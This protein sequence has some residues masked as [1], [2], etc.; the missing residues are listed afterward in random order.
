MLSLQLIREHPDEVRS[1]LAR[2]GASDAPPGELLRPDAQRRRTL[3]EVEALR[4]ERNALPK[5]VGELARLM[6]PAETREAKHAEHRRSDLVARSSFLGDK[7]DA[8]ETQLRDLDGDLRDL[9]LQVPNLPAD[10]VPEGPDDSANVVVETE[11]E[12]IEPT[13]H[14]PHWDLGES[15]RIIDFERGAKLS[16]S[17]FYVLNGA[18]ARL[19]RALIALMLDLHAREGRYT[20]VYLPAM[21]KEDNMLAAGQ[22]PKLAD[23][24]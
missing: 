9:L 18:G 3:Q 5:G 15:L 16:G 13:F 7:L 4:G 12:P 17:R 24:L 20:E 23:N 14:K 11:G 1:G 6:K 2:R 19:Q 10:S 8:L 22:L 21:V